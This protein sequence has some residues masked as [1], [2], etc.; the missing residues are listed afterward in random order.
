MPSGDVMLKVELPKTAFA[1]M[2]RDTKARH[3]TCII[4]EIYPGAT[5]T[6]ILVCGP[7]A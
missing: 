7:T 5:D 6:M 4:K 3:D 2:N 1:M